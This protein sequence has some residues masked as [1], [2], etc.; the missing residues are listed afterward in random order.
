MYTIP[1]YWICIGGEKSIVAQH[2]EMTGPV[3]KHR[4]TNLKMKRWLR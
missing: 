1:Y 3:K 2:E 4:N